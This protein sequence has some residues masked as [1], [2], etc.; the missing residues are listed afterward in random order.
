M[1]RPR[2]VPCLLIHNGGLVKTVRFK[3]SKYLG[4]PLNAVKIFNEKQVDELI[5]LDID[6]RVKGLDPN[7]SLISNLASECRMPLCYGGGIQSVDQIE[8]IIGLGVE[9]VALGAVSAYDSS[10]IERAAH[11]VG[12]QSI[13]SVIDV[14]KVG[15][16]QRYEVVTHNAAKKVGMSPVDLACK[17]QSL[18]AGEILLNSVDKDGTMQGY[19]LPLIDSV[20]NAVS[21]PLTVLGGASSL[22]EMQKLIEMYGIIGLAAGSIFVFHGKHRAVLI[23]YPQPDQKDSL[24]SS[25]SNYKVPFEESIVH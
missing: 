7:Y 5:V 4:D 24:C 23:Q 2:V 17:M 3:D 19:D 20:R 22:Q 12:S 13:V 14:K 21:L 18:G 11:R 9:K 8:R 25:I 1:L 10:V 15:F 6:A 16:R